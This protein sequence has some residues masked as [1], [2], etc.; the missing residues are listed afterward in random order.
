MQNFVEDCNQLRE[1]ST[2]EPRFNEPL[3]NKNLDITNGILCPSNS[4]I[5]VKEPQYDKPSI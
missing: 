1:F 5:Y 4:K 2:V 3:F